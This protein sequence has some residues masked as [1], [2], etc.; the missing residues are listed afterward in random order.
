[1]VSFRRLEALA[2]TREV[3]FTESDQ[4]IAAQI[5]ERGG[6]TKVAICGAPSGLVGARHPRFSTRIK[7]QE[8]LEKRLRAIDKDL[9]ELMD[10]YCD[11]LGLGDT[12]GTELLN[13]EFLAFTALT[14]RRAAAEMGK[15]TLEKTY[16]DK[17]GNAVGSEPIENPAVEV[18][19]KAVDR[20]GA[21]GREQNL[22]PRSKDEKGREDVMTA[23]LARQAELLN[24]VMPNL[25]PPAITVE[26]E[27]V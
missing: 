23:V 21:T 26:A 24:R 1:M 11:H 5:G 22:T 7:S 13:A 3:T 16:Y 4:L 19:M 18:F 15:V 2:S 20:L 17:L 27:T 6:S 14:A 8:A 10:A 25:P 9:P 12:S